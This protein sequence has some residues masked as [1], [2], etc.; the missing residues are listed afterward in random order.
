MYWWIYLLLI[1]YVCAKAVF[2]LESKI[3]LFTFESFSASSKG[4]LGLAKIVVF[5]FKKVQT[6]FDTYL[7]FVTYFTYEICGEKIIMWRNFRFLCTTDVE[8]SEISQ[9]FQNFISWSMWRNQK[10]FHLWHVCDVEIVSTNVKCCKINFF[11]IYAVLSQ[12]QFCR[13]S[14]TFVWRKY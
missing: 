9:H 11:A 12:N 7:I 13:N 10:K 3:A 5:C 14:R 1:W 2:S 6:D 4:T 8:K